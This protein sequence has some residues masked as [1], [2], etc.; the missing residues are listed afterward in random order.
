MPGAR[1]GDYKQVHSGNSSQNHH[2]TVHIVCLDAHRGALPHLS[3][4]LFIANDSNAHNHHY[5][6]LDTY[7]S[8]IFS[9]L[10]SFQHRQHLPHNSHR[11]H[12]AAVAGPFRRAHKARTK[13]VQEA[14]QGESMGDAQGSVHVV[15]GA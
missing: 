4:D 14:R 12:P 6:R 9:K 8:P 15:A 1:G 13:S 3:P 10:P 2:K 5:G 11:K 7:L